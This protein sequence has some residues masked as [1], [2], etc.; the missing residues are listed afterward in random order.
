[1]E[2]E[3]SVA[4]ANNFIKWGTHQPNKNANVFKRLKCALLDVMSAEDL[5][6]SKY[7]NPPYFAA[8]T[9]AKAKLCYSWKGVPGQGLETVVKEYGIKNPNDD[10][11][12]ILFEIRSYRSVEPDGTKRYYIEGQA[13][14]NNSLGKCVSAPDKNRSPTMSYSLEQRLALVWNIAPGDKDYSNDLNWKCL[15][16]MLRHWVGLSF[17]K[18]GASVADAEK[19]CRMSENP[20]PMEEFGYLGWVNPRKEGVK[21]NFR[22]K[23]A[24]DDLDTGSKD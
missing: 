22:R 4:D 8:D 20:S 21:P 17:T 6:N 9:H 10:I 23:G 18:H 2:N 5:G 7:A 16:A 1:M 15:G 11:D 3:D 19:E 13:T 12:N 24:E 14:V